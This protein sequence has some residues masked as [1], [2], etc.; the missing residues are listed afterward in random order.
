[1]AQL[2][3]ASDN[4]FEVIRKT[5]D[6][7]ILKHPEATIPLS[8]AE[9]DT[10]LNVGMRIEA[11]VYIDHQKGLKATMIKPKIDLYNAAFVTVVETKE[12]L[13]VFVDIGLQ[14]DMLVSKDDLPPLKKHWPKVGDCLLCYLKVGRNQMTA[15]PVDRFRVNQYLRPDKPLEK[16]Q[17]VKAYVFHIAE[18]GLVLYTEE[19]HEIFVY[20]KN[21]RESHRLGEQVKATIILKKDDLHYNGTLIQQ[22]ENQI[23]K[24]AEIILEYLEENG[25]MPYTDKSDPDEIFKVFHMSKSAFKR[26][27]GN[28]YRQELVDLEKT[29]TVLKKGK[30]S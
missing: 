4:L 11:F 30:E 29:R 9:A 17:P 22:K 10:D 2:K 19:G 25:E 12:K 7:Y 16:G 24:D 20:H 18:E 27:L 14:K 1:M 21:M 28:L 5:K 8:K 13:G 6:E 23:S 15:R 26:A 3:I